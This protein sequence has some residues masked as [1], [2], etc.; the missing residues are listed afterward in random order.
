MAVGVA[1]MTVHQV[2]LRT[3]RFKPD[4]PDRWQLKAG[5]RASIAKR[6]DTNEIADFNAAC[7]A[8]GLVQ[9]WVARTGFFDLYNLIPRS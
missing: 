3:G 7:V 2:Y 6:P 8:A 9:R 4:H 1:E 5:D